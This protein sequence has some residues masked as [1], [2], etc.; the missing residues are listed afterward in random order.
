[1]NVSNQQ[2]LPEN[3]KRRRNGIR[4]NE[5]ILIESSCGFYRFAK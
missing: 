3:K 5:Q 4:N 2:L 1:M